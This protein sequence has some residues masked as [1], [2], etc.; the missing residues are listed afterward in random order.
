MMISFQ[1]IK[2]AL[3]CSAVGAVGL[4]GTALACENW[5]LGD[6]FNLT[7]ANGAF[8]KVRDVHKSGDQIEASARYSGNGG[9]L[10]GSLYSDGRLKFTV[11]WDNGS[12]GDYTA[13]VEE[14]G[15]VVDGRTYDR[16]HP[17]SW[18]KWR[19]HA[20]ECDD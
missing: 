18:S 6:A 11:R 12:V 1:W 4:P 16:S 3:I 17:A 13:H 5:V 2:S 8:V 10:S 9:Y 14:S 20:I 7:Q 15:E 19:M